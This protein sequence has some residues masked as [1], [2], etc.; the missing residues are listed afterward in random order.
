MAGMISAAPTPSRNAHPRMRIPRF[1]ARE[2]VRE[3]APYT[4]H[5]IEKARRRPIRLPIF[6]P[7][8]IIV[9]ITSV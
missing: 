5:P 2:V 8:I 6:P 4:T 1:G 3:P 9:A 7:V